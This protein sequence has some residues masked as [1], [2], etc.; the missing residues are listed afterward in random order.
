M[1]ILHIFSTLSKDIFLSDE[2]FY[3]FC[4]VIL[5]PFDQTDLGIATGILA[6]LAVFGILANCLTIYVICRSKK[7]K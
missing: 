1:G 2:M 5:F 3:L 6:P 4:R 7:L